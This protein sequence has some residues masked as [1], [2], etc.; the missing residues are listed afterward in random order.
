VRRFWTLF[1]PGTIVAVNRIIG[2]DLYR[3]SKVA[4]LSKGK[5]KVMLCMI[6]NEAPKERG[7][8]SNPFKGYRT[9]TQIVL[10]FATIIL[11]LPGF[12]LMPLIQFN[13][14]I[15]L[16]KPTIFQMAMTLSAQRQYL[17]HQRYQYPCDGDEVFFLIVDASRR[18]SRSQNW[19]TRNE[20]FRFKKA[21]R[22]YSTF[23]CTLN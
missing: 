4:P 11:I 2:A 20:A 1:C 5:D 10:W 18:D 6:V 15:L 12:A 21:R 17:P 23:L 13:S 22:S 9:S 19:L 14:N 3:N 7:A 8:G 16:R